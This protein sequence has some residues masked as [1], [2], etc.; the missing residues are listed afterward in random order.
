M[1]QI[2]GFAVVLLAA[3]CAD[4][5]PQQATVDRMYVIDCG[6]NHV[7]DLSRWTPGENVG[8]PWVFG[9]HCYLIRHANAWMLW[10]SGNP[11]R[12][13]ALPNGLTNPQGTITAFMRKPLEQSLLELNVRPQ[14]ITYFAMSHSHGDHSGNA[15]L[16]ARSNIF[17]QRAEYE[18][19]YG[20]EPQKFGFAAANFEKLKGGKFVLLDGD[21]DVFGDGSVIILSTPGHTPGHQSLLVRLKHTGPV[22]LTGDLVHLRYSW[23]HD[24]VPAFNFDV[25]KSHESIARMKALVESTGAQ[26]WVNH[27]REQH[28]GIP[29][30]PGFVD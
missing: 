7:G 22:L 26:V 15:N 18:A 9:D 12:L 11:D 21:G 6:E 30:A 24:I 10:D 17:M 19:V 25:A 8:K 27:D 14:D 3:A 23:D 1:K 4:I 16:F 29:Q 5:A 2:L 13:A 20:P 28:S